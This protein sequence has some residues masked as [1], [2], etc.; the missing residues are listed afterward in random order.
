MANLG[1]NNAIAIAQAYYEQSGMSCKLPDNQNAID[2]CVNLYVIDRNQLPP[3]QIPVAVKTA[4]KSAKFDKIFLEVSS[5]KRQLNGTVKNIS[6]W[7]E[8][9][10]AEQLVIVDEQGRAGFIIDWVQAK[11]FIFQNMK[12]PSICEVQT[13]TNKFDSH[14]TTTTVIVKLSTLRQQ[15]LI[16]DEFDITFA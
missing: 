9:C 11:N 6:G 2:K 14:T 8:R 13:K 12:N 4:N 5:K 3:K 15:N 10:K 16:V 1:S 7:F